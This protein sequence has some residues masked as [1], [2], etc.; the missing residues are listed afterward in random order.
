MDIIQLIT[1]QLG[2]DAIAKLSSST[3]ETPEAT[4]KAVQAAVPTLL[5]A[6]NNNTNSGG[7]AS[8]LSALDKNHDGSI[9]D[10]VMGFFNNTDGS[11]GNG[12]LKH[13]LGS[14]QST[15]EQGLSSAS[16]VSAPSMGKILAML[17]PIVMGY[18][19][20]QKKENGISSA[21]GISDLLTSVVGSLGNNKGGGIDIS[22]ILSS[23]GGNTQSQGGSA[24][25]GLLGLLG[26]FLKK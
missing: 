23:L 25:G 17:A 13:V 12:I 18:L 9:L 22:S 1:N 2:G 5:N 16:G 3:G 21:N 14:Q 24:S 8:L 10:D 26:K 19:G 20:R 11:E 6:L 15:V 7:A 4:A